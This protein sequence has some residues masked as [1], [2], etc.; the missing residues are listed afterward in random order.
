MQFSN[1]YL[2][3]ERISAEKINCLACYRYIYATLENDFDLDS[4]VRIPDVPANL[5]QKTDRY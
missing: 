4:L 2:L 3:T 5:V 1:T